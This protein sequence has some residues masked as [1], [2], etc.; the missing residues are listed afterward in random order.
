MNLSASQQVKADLARLVPLFES[1]FLLPF[2]DGEAPHLAEAMVYSLQAGGKRIRPVL[3]MLAAEAVGAAA[4]S[5][6]SCAVAL[7]Y[8]H[9]YSLIHDDLPA[10]DDDDLRR[11]KP[12]CHVA[13]GEGPAIL[14]G[15]G[16]LTEAFTHLASDPDLPPSR[17]VDALRVLGEAAGWRGMVGGQALDLEGEAR[18]RG[19]EPV[20]LA[21]L[22]QIHR[23]KTGALLRASLELGAIAGCA[24]RED[25]EALRAAG[26]AIGLAFQ[27]QDD[28]LDATS[29]TEAMGKRVGKDEGRGKITYPLL[30]GLQGA[31]KALQEA[32][33]RA[34]CQLASLPNPLSLTALATYLAERGA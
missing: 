17:R 9:T 23:L 16:L 30:L 1:R 13:F 28:I 11:G 33:E 25:R 10:M 6:L 18:T 27:I 15:D 12:T 20:T 19:G 4:A 2:A 31:R 26:E 24:S 14:A 21:G 34:R 3:C 22:Q 29:T 8:I 7:E 32:T 5:A